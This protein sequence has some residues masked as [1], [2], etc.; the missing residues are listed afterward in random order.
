MNFAKL[1]SIF[2]QARNPPV[3]SEVLGAVDKVLVS[4]YQEMQLTIQCLCAR[5]DQERAQLRALQVSKWTVDGKLKALE[6][7]VRPL[8]ERVQSLEA[9]EADFSAE[10]ATLQQAVE[11]AESKV[12]EVDEALKAKDADLVVALEGIQATEDALAERDA[13]I[14]AK[15]SALA[16]KDAALA[17]KD[18]ALAGKEAAIKENGEVIKQQEVE[19]VS[20]TTDASLLTEYKMCVI[21]HNL[22]PNLKGERIDRAWRDGL[23]EKEHDEAEAWL[24]RVLV[25]GSEH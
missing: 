6:A 4:Q 3:L 22:F 20:R 23:D 2:L 17:E 13:T 24:S 12:Q 1:L 7:E 8:K 16:E 19:L 9:K 11:A 5:R 15:D 10:K 18:A 21:M 14:A 25:S